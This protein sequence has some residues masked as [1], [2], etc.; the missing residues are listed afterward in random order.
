[1][2]HDELVQMAVRHLH[3]TRRCAVVIRERGSGLEI[4]DVIGWGTAGF[5]IVV[6]CKVSMPDFY[7]DR[8]KLGR[9][10]NP[11]LGMG[12]ERY[13]LVPAGLLKRQEVFKITDN[14]RT[15]PYPQLPAGWGLL[16]A[17]SGRVFRVIDVPPRQ[18]F[19]DRAERRLLLKEL[20]DWMMVGEGFKGPS[21]IWEDKWHLKEH[22]N[23][24]YEAEKSKLLDRRRPVRFS[25]TGD[26]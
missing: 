3:G 13:Y 10:G 22:A 25:L 5:S 2:T 8:K 1:M 6:E 9:R 12:Q 16:E 7:A 18:D 17:R 4:P 26:S 19:N 20:Q 24:S 21:R 15:D 23:A 11:G 14:D